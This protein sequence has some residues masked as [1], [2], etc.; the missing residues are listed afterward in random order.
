MMYGVQLLNTHWLPVPHNV[1]WVGTGGLNIAAFLMEAELTECADLLRRLAGAIDAEISMLVCQAFIESRMALQSCA[2]RAALASAK[3]V[4]SM[5]LA[6]CQ[7][8]RCCVDKQLTT[9][10][11]D[12]IGG[13]YY[14]STD[15]RWRRGCDPDAEH[16]EA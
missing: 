16:R 3:S 1:L 14:L 2:C 8:L 9:N 5:R 7:R 13:L 11:W 10:E 12:M 6:A 15:W 4:F